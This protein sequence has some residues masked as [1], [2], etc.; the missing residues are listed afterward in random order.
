MEIPSMDN[1]VIVGEPDLGRLMLGQGKHGVP[2]LYHPAV[3]ES[4]KHLYVAYR[5]ELAQWQRSPASGGTVDGT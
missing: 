5:D 2:K 4:I 1:M 3:H